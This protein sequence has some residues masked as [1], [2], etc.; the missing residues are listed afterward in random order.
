MLLDY[1]GKEWYKNK[2]EAVGLSREDDHYSVDDRFR[3]DMTCW[4]KIF[5]CF[6]TKSGEHIQEQLL[7]W[8]HMEAYN[9][10]QYDYVQGFI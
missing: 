3:S 6:N 1:Q 7:S 2:L 9:Y 10:F 8:K 5:T 4:P